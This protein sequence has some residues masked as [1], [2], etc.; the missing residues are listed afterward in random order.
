MSNDTSSQLQCC[1]WASA[2]SKGKKGWAAHGR[3]NG[4]R[5]AEAAKEG[6]GTINVPAG[7]AVLDGIAPGGGA[8]GIAAGAGLV[9]DRANPAWISPVAEPAAVSNGAGTITAC[10]GMNGIAATGWK[11][12]AGTA[13]GRVG[14]VTAGAATGTMPSR[15]G[16]AT[17]GSIVIEMAAVA[18]DG[19]TIA[20]T[21]EAV[22][23]STG[24]GA[25][26]SD[27]AAL[28]GVAAATARLDGAESTSRLLPAG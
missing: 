19:T 23:A 11:A 9:P 2:R 4:R 25:C 26:S 15:T 17:E 22:W 21:T 24:A 7:N 1:V 3:G 27:G 16:C 8:A 5:A 12:A 20:G 28:S 6:P 14:V 10:G 18:I 13:D